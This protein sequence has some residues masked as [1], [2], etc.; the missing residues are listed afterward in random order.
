VERG[1][2]LGGGGGRGHLTLLQ[3]ARA[4]GCP[5]NRLFA[6]AVTPEGSETHAWILAQPA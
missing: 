6:A 3:W 4:N 2:L 5:W 1:H